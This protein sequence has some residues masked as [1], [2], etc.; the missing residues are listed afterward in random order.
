MYNSNIPPLYLSHFLSFSFSC[1]HTNL[2]R[3]L[4]ACIVRAGPAPTVTPDPADISLRKRKNPYTY[5]P[6]ATQ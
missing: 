5:P 1:T 6:T 4:Q 3:L 2:I